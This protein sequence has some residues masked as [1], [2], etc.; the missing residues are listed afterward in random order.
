MIEIEWEGPFTFTDVSEKHYSKEINY[1]L[2][3]IYG[4][5]ATSGPETLLYIGKACDQTF[6]GRMKQHSKRL[7]LK[8][9]KLK[10][11]LADLEVLIY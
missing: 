4:N 3:C 7:K 6:A 9:Q 8:I 5:H 1:G 2:Y 10:S 11:S